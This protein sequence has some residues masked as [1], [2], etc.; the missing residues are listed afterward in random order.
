MSGPEDF[1]RFS[2]DS[3]RAHMPESYYVGAVV[4][5][6][7]ASFDCTHVWVE[8]PYRNRV[9]LMGDAAGCTDPTHSQ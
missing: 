2:R 9:A 4:E 3:N 1:A 7:L 8:Y 5:R 6:P